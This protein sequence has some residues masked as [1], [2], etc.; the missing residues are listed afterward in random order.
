M[1]AL[2]FDSGPLINFSMSGLLYLLEEL[3]RR[4]QGKFFITEQVKYEVIDRPIK[5]PKFEL[6]A[7]MIKNLLAKK[8]IEFPSS[9]EIDSEL[10]KK[11]T[12]FFMKKAN[13]SMEAGGREI[14]ILSEG[15]CSCLALSSELSKKE[16]DN[17]IAIDE[18]TTRILTESPR[19]LEE[20]M[21]KKLNTKVNFVG[22]LNTFKNFKF[23]RSTELVYVAYKKGLLKIEGPNVLEAALYA[24]KFHGSSIS[25]DEINILKKL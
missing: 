12:S 22:D 8:I 16:I 13:S 6:G 11:Q 20:F 7:L 5:V 9:L 18:R 19:N 1:K 24:A 4:F 3:K 23:I 25:F 17:V 21:S 15:E 2:I 10:I 14:N